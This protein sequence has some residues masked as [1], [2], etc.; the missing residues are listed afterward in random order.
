MAGKSEKEILILVD[1]P[2]HGYRCGDVVRCS[3][4]LAERLEAQGLADGNPKAVE[5]RRK[6]ASK[7]SEE[8][9]R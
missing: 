1:A 7:A 5:P 2:H 6:A 8:S 4:D 3:S 9:K